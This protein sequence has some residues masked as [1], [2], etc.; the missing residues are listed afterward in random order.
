MAK[1]FEH[2]PCFLCRYPCLDWLDSKN[3]PIDTFCNL[4]RITDSDKKRSSLLMD[5][6]LCIRDSQ[7]ILKSSNTY[8][9]IFQQI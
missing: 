6:R 7:S 5:W 2:S 8:G 1:Y 9:R 4:S 3:T